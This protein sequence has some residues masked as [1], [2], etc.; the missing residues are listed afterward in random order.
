MTYDPNADRDYWRACDDRRLSTAARESEHELAIA[1]GE[2]LDDLTDLEDELRLLRIER[3]ELD[4]RIDDLRA[5][6]FLLLSADT[7]TEPGA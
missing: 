3:D 6:L 1:L 7:E 2:R 4:R 5:E